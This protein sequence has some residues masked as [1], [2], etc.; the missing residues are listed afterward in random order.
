MKMEDESYILEVSAQGAE[1]TRVYDK[2]HQRELLWNADPAYW[3]HHSP[4]L[5][6]LVGSCQGG[7]F[8]YQGKTYQ[9]PQHGFA[10]RSLFSVESASLTSLTLSLTASEETKKCYP[11]DFL[12]FVSYVLIDGRV[13]V[14]YL[15]RNQSERSPMYFSVGAHPGFSLS[16]ALK[17]QVIRF[18]R[19]EN[20]DR[21]LVTPDALFSRDVI[22]DDV[23]DG[24]PIR[25]DAHTFDNDALVYHNFQSEFVDVKNEQ[26][27]TGVRVFLGKFPYVGFW[28]APGAPFVCVEP[29]FGLADYTD[30]DGE[31]P[32]K[33]GIQK[34]GPGGVF[35]ARFAFCGL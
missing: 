6:P 28:S 24:G 7:K 18:S 26:T 14:S 29:W 12:F 10:S 19:R 32:E 35:K 31:L 2:K 17:D 5:F 15:V 22:R 34:L 8:R 20:L 25:L 9:L 21:L 1:M 11:F 33:D 13:E 27:G 30:F 4:V 23:R 16:G 3:D